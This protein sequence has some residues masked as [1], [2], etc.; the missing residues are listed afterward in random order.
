MEA[1]C[2]TSAQQEKKTEQGQ[3]R[4][5]ETHQTQNMALNS[6]EGKMLM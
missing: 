5:H 1:A 3:Q 4:E 6:S 2:Q